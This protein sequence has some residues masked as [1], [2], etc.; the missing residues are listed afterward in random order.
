MIGT[1]A[2][3]TRAP[4]ILPIVPALADALAELP[5]SDDPEAFIFPEIAA[6]TAGGRSKRFRRILYEAGLVGRRTDQKT[7]GVG[8]ASGRR[9]VSE[10]SFHSMRHTAT[11]LLKAAGVSDALTRSIVGHESAAV[12]KNYTHMPVEAMR[13]ALEKLKL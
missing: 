2:R 3:K 7:K 1:E 11:T 10:L 5:S 4:I 12:S 9:Q 8:K 13:E 6:L